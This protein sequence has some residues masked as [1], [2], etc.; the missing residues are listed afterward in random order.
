MDLHGVPNDLINNLN[1]L[2]IVIMIPILDIIVYPTLRKLKIRFSPVKRMAAGFFIASGAMVW[3]AVVQ[4]YIYSRGAC[5]KYM[6][7][8]ETPAPLNVWI[9][10]GSVRFSFFF[11]FHLEAFLLRLLWYL[12]KSSI[13]LLDWV[14]SWHPSQGLSMHIPKLPLIWEV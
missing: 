1:P 9:Q 14:K 7:D 4:H 11:S 12:T 2:G 8:C 3:A 13:S 6:N 10:A 5:G